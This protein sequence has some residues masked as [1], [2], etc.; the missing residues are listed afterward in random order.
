MTNVNLIDLNNEQDVNGGEL[1]FTLLLD[2]NITIENENGYFDVPNKS[3][4]FAKRPY[5]VITTSPYIKGYH[6]VIKNQ[7]NTK[8]TE[9]NTEICDQFSEFDLCDLK[10]IALK[11]TILENVTKS[12]NQE[13][14][15]SSIHLVLNQIIEENT[16]VQ[17]TI[18]EQFEDLIT[19]N[20]NKNYCAGKYAEILN[21]PIKKLISEVKA[22]TDNLTPCN[23]ITAKVVEEAKHLLTTTK[24]SSKTIS[25]LLGF[26]DPYYFIK[27]F[28]KSTDYTPTQ[29]RKLKIK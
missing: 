10:E 17:K 21:I 22:N 5:R 13:L 15:E 28:K 25:Y 11:A 1:Y 29:Y 16:C 7:S 3:F 8:F 20:I 19:E 9:T 4:F 2:G 23:I 6:I 18:F 26:S 14:I 27:Y 12:K 24:H